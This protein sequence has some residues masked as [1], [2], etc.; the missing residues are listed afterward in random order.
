MVK[1]KY[2]VDSDTRIV[3]N[4]ILVEDGFIIPGKELFD[5]EGIECAIGW[6]EQ[7]GI[8]VPPADPRTADEIKADLKNLVNNLRESKQA[9]GF[10]DNGHVF[11]IGIEAQKDMLGVQMQFMLGAQSPHGGFWRDKDNNEVQMDDAAVVA[12]LQ[13]VF[14]HVFALKAAA[15][16]HKDMI[17]ALESV[18]ELLAYDTGAGWP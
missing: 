17:E 10:T 13:R 15:W 8:F 3:E 5:A 4:F 11:Q 12:F 9:A 18:E 1:S 14:A 6:R 7:D 16:H 2:V